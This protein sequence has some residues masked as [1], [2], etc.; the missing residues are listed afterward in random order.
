MTGRRLPGIA[1]AC[2]ALLLLGAAAGVVAE[3]QVAMKEMAVAAKT[4]AQTFDGTHP[5]DR[6]AVTGAAQ[7][8][9][10]HSGKALTAQFPPG[11]WGGASSATD[12]VDRDP[13]GFAA[14]ADE[15]HDLALVFEDKTSQATGLTPA[16]R[17]GAG[18]AGGGGSLLGRK[19]A[20]PAPADQS[21]E[22]VFHLMLETCTR[23]H[24]AYRAGR[25]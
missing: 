18:D 22:H 2:A 4:I 21:A 16:M 1:A 25:P 24:A 13:T 12:E 23:C 10:R 20:T 11:T 15:L 19:R 3:R 8:L 6:A 9:A 7:T 17:M 5:Y 14:L